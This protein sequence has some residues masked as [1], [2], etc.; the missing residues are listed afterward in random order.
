MS[1]IS[2]QFV[3]QSLEVRQPPSWTIIR[4]QNR[5]DRDFLHGLNPFIAFRISPTIHSGAASLCRKVPDL[6]IPAM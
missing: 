6:R 2:H 1:D 4:L 3:M 5:L